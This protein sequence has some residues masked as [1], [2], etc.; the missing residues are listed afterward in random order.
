MK[1]HLVNLVLCVSTI[2][3]VLVVAEKGLEQAGF[4]CRSIHSISQTDYEKLP[5][6]YH[7]NTDIVVSKVRGLPHR[8]RIN[9]LGF[10][11]PE[12]SLG[13]ARPRVLFIG[14][15]FTYGDGVDEESTLPAHVAR[16]LGR[17]AEVLNGGVAVA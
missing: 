14:D 17:R 4:P 9:S 1:R 6:M 3:V 5:G 16:R 8:V 12:V 7:P 13:A 10:R 11:G 15:S 2:M